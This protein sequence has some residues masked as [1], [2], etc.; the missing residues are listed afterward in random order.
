MSQPSSPESST[1]KADFK[2]LSIATLALLA[3]AVHLTLRYAW[4]WDEWTAELPLLVA[5]TLGGT[6][7]VWEL[8]QKLLRQTH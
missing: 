3:I 5:L 8:L 1:P 4:S 7:L 2:Q 6:P